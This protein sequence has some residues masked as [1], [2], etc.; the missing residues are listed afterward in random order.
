[1]VLVL[2]DKLKKRCEEYLQKQALELDKLLDPIHER[3]V[4]SGI[5]IPVWRS[6]GSKEEVKGI[7]IDG[8]LG[9]GEAGGVWGL[10]VKTIECDDKSGAVL[11]CRI[12]KLGALSPFI[13]ESISELQELLK[14]MDLVLESRIRDLIA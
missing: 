10:L 7:V 8:F 14:E 2:L 9:Y 12:E 1:M 13:K 5:R 4:A 3:F 6:L 11:S